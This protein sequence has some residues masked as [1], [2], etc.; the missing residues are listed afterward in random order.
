MCWERGEGIDY[1][2]AEKEGSCEANFLYF[3]GFLVKFG[4]NL[5]FIRNNTVLA[6]GNKGNKGNSLRGFV[7]EDGVPFLLNLYSCGN[8]ILTGTPFSRGFTFGVNML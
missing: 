1:C 3:L 7:V 6:Q 2:E 5:G 8:S 4:D